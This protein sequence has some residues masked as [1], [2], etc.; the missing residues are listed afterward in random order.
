MSEE[1]IGHGSM[2]FESPQY[3]DRFFLWRDVH[4][5]GVFDGWGRRHY[6]KMDTEEGSHQFRNTD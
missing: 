2:A 3:P 1:S 5:D 6:C 4:A